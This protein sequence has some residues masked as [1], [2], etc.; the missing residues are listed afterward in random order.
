[1]FPPQVFYLGAA[2]LYLGNFVFAYMNILGCLRRQQYGS[3]KYALLSPIYWALMSIAAWKGFIQLFYA[4]SY[5][6]KTN[7]GLYKADGS[8]V[9]IFLSD[10]ASRQPERAKLFEGGS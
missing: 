5:W 10:G 7:H 9:G 3:I 4:P 8:G 6:E 1:M 2:A